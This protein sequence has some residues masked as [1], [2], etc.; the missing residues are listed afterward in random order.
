MLVVSRT[1][2]CKKQSCAGAAAEQRLWNA[3]SQAFEGSE[4]LNESLLHSDS[5]PCLGLTPPHQHFDPE[6]HQPL[7]F[8]GAH[9]RPQLSWAPLYSTTLSSSSPRQWILGSGDVTVTQNVPSLDILLCN[10]FQDA[11]SIVMGTTSTPWT[12]TLVGV[13]PSSTLPSQHSVLGIS[14]KHT[15]SSRPLS[16]LQ[17][18]PEG[19][20]RCHF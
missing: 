16:A 2:I 20:R 4:R 7:C 8:T 14:Q 13:S 10:N 5:N 6:Y 17:K 11:R 18:L 12:P 15:E 1:C 9:W 3:V 19:Q